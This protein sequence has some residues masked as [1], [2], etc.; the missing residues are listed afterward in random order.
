[1][2]EFHLDIYET[3]LK[4]DEIATEIVIPPSLPGARSGY[5]RFSGNSPTDWPC[6]G[7]AAILVKEDGRCKEMKISLG[8]LTPVP[9]GFKE[10]A[11][12][13][14]G[15]K[16]TPAVA[17]KFARACAARIDPIPDSRGSEWY[18]RRIAEV[19]ITRIIERLN[20]END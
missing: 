14:R 16:L 18:K 9:V 8:S 7:V 13:I 1:M 20:R 15:K 12:A 2:E 5:L 17:K 10:E 3:A 11:E 4:E 19:Y 6:L